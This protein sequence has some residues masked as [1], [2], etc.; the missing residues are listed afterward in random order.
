MINSAD[1]TLLEWNTGIT[2]ADMPV[3]VNMCDFAW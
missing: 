3:F 2:P 1:F